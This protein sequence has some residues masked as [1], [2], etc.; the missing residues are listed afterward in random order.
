MKQ[1]YIIPLCVA[2]IVLTASLSFAAERKP[3]EVKKTDKCQVCGMFVAKYKEWIAQVI[4][5]DGTY[6]VFDGPKDMFRY[7]VNPSKYNPSKKQSDI[8]T[9]YVT[10]YYSTKLMDAREV[11]YVSGSDVT[12]PMGAELVPLGSEQ[13]AKEFMKDHNGKKILK[14]SDITAEVLD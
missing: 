10:E 1:S 11:F 5:T 3:V 2:G 13:K 4:F 14:F 9:L 6:A 7:Y 8:Q 12:G